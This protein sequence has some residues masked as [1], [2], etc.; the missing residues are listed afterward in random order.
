L[1]S[2]ED[3]DLK[4]LKMAIK[5]KDKLIER[6]KLQIVE[7]YRK[8]VETGEERETTDQED[9]AIITLKCQIKELED[10]VEMLKQELQKVNDKLSNTNT[11]L[12][13][14]QGD[15]NT[16]ILGEMCRR[17]QENVYR[18]VFPAKIPINSKVSY[19]VKNLEG[20]IDKKKKL[21]DP[22]KKAAR[23]RLKNLKKDF[24]WDPDKESLVDEIQSLRNVKAHPA[25]TEDIKQKVV[26]AVEELSEEKLFE[27]M[28]SSSEDARELIKIWEKTEELR[29]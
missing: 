7:R 24:N 6:Y 8:L 13:T 5:S 3:V 29:D 14:L 4:Q 18:Y 23:K 19:K 9:T 12:K 15:Q 20:E 17:L 28:N 11:E 1:S 21:S 16:L 10:E 2:G 25:M 22:E 26:N 27:S